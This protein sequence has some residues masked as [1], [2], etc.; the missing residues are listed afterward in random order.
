MKKKEKLLSE[1]SNYNQQTQA[2]K[3][4][5]KREKEDHDGKD[6]D[7]QQST[8]QIGFNKL[9]VKTKHFMKTIIEG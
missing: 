6:K 1:L 2:S 8:N 9:Q 4:R 5:S 7:T 3:M